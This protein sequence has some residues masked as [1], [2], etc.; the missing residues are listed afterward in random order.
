[1][2]GVATGE[3]LGTLRPRRSD[4]GGKWSEGL[5]RESMPV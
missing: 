2:E 1:M 3:G 4:T 5:K